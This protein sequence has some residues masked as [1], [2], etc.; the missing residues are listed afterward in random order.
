MQRRWTK[1]IQGLEDLPYHDRLSALD[2][3]SVRGRLLR[4]DLIECWKIMH[5]YASFDYQKLFQCA[6]D[7]RTRGH[8]YKL[9]HT[10]SFLEC[11][12][13][14]FSHR[15]VATWNSLPPS[16]AELDDIGCFKSAL[17]SVLGAKLYEYYQ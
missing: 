4:A 17:K 14:F 16:V 13:R 8:A 10:R 2:L 15:V 6:P 7:A 1:H 5:G 3:F 9:A 11:R 12:R